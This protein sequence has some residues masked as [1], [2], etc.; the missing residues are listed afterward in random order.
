MALGAK[1]RQV[2]WL[3]VRQTLTLLLVGLGLG[4]AGALA[5][6]RLLIAFLGDISPRDPATVVTVAVLLST[7]A[8]AAG[9][10]PARRAAASTRRSRFEQIDH[11]FGLTSIRVATLRCDASCSESPAYGPDGIGVRHHSLLGGLVP[12]M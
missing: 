7:V 4:L 3:F 12:S 1:A 6:T 2:M 8:L 11:F 10:G 5:T 9:L